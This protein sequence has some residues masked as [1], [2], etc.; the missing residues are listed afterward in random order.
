[1]KYWLRFSYT[2]SPVGLFGLN[3]EAGW[4]YL[5]YGVHLWRVGVWGRIGKRRGSYAMNETVLGVKP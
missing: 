3:I 1:M 5:Y 2:R 4:F